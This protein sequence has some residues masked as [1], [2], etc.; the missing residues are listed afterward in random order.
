MG[1]LGRVMLVGVCGAAAVAMGCGSGRAAR[2]IA[3]WLDPK[4]VTSAIMTAA[5]GDGDGIL[6]GAELDTV[7]ALAAAVES[8]DTNADNALSAEELVAWFQK[9]KESRVAITSLA[10]TV[11]HKGRPLADA[12]VR[13]VPEAC[14][15]R[16]TKAA[17]GR[18][19]K[20]GS[21]MIT[22]PGSTYPGVNCGLY[23]V[24]ITGTG[25]DGNPLPA[26]FNTS[27]K[28]GVAVGGALPANG[29]VRFS[30]D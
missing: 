12:T 2:V 26:A 14:M 6:R 23:R 28:R 7:P 22:I 15:G 1:L 16:D 11:T 17:E 27:S 13:L 25:A 10:A 29:M 24:E 3:P 9:V 8:L 19:D 20:D 18:T 4:A 21:T 30:L 5:D